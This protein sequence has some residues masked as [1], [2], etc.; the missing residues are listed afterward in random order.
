MVETS[1]SEKK[2]LMN[3]NHG[4]ADQPVMGTGI[5]TTLDMTGET[6]DMTEEGD[7]I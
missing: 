5:S 3:H 2:D 4:S 7:N 6:L 1:P